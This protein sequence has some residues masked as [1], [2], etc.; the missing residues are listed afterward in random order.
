MIILCSSIVVISCSHS[1]YECD[2]RRHIIRPNVCVSPNTVITQAWN[3]TLPLCRHVTH[4]C[5]KHFEVQI[6]AVNLCLSLAICLQRDAERGAASAQHSRAQPP[7]GRELPDLLP[8]PAGD[9]AVQTA[10]PRKGTAL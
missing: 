4:S 8:L 1:K 7:P 5:P 10:E 2:S 6:S 9:A 3:L